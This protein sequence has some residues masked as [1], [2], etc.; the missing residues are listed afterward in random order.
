[1]PINAENAF[2]KIQHAFMIKSLKKQDIEGSQLNTIKAKY[3]KL[4]AN[5]IFNGE[6]HEIISSKIMTETKKLTRTQHP[7]SI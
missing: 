1:M 3:G 6:K 5:I 4:K 7:Y 2:Y